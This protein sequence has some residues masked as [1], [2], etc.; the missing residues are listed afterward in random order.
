MG[1]E[2]RSFFALTKWL[3]IILFSLSLAGCGVISDG[4]YT[5]SVV[6]TGGSG[7]AYIESPCTVTVTGNKAM[8]HIVWSSPNYDYMIVDGNTYYPVNSE[9]NSEFEIP[10]SLGKEMSIQADT[11]AMGTPHLIDYTLLIS[12]EDE[13]NATNERA[14][15]I[16][17]NSNKDSDEDREENSN[18]ISDKDDKNVASAMS[19]PEIDGLKYISTDENDYAG[20]FKIHRY[21]GEYVVISIDDG[22]N[23]LIIPRDKKEPENL[24]PDII[25]LKEPQRIYLAASGAMCHFDSLDALDRI[26]MSGTK[27]DDWYI[28]SAKKAMEEG[29]IIYSGK[30]N[31]PDYEQIVKKDVDLAIE[32]TMILHVPK[33]QEQLEKLGIP[34][35]IDRSSYETEPLGRCEWI[36]VYGVITGKEDVAD[37]AFLQQKRYF[38]DLDLSS[39]EK[40][41][42]AVFSLNS[43]HQIVTRKA[44]DY[45]AKMI[46]MAGGEYLSP[47]G[48]EENAVSSTTI[49]IEAFYE[50][51]VD[52]DILIYNATIENIPKSLDELKM[53]DAIFPELKAVREKEVWYTEKSLYQSTDKSGTIIENLYEIIAEGKE[54][55]GFF[56]K[57]K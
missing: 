25:S 23:Y 18:L 6:M 4:E 39:V 27:K 22:R 52:A 33:V 9:G 50:Y 41:K 31:S 44:D 37:N 28:D 38:T 24:S 3:F 13:E 51:A 40:K 48:S 47:K 56:R 21:E 29:K 36:K 8:A 45:F 20:C 17:E 42:V 46:T 11:V 49:S 26:I 1:K 55:A 15:D 19:P 34:V 12:L 43:N 7:K 10:V 53:A 14:Q 16:E 30:Y 54:D 5:A 32:N 2:Q 35:F 57:L